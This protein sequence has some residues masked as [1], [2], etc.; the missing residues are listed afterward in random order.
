MIRAGKP[1][2][3]SVNVPSPG[4]IFFFETSKCLGE[5][6]MSKKAAEHHRKASEHLTRAARHHD[7]AAKHYDTGEHAMGGHH[8]HTAGGH[9]VHARGHAEE[10]VKA[11]V[12]EHGKK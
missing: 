5:I 1:R 8:A 11:H 9:V 12:E 2:P 7:E 10:A 4:A 3:G 6:H